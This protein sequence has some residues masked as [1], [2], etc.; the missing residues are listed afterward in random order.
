[1]RKST[2]GWSI[3]LVLL[4]FFGGVANFLQMSMQS[5][6]QGVLLISPINLLTFFLSF[7]TLKFELTFITFLFPRFLEEHV[8]KYRKAFGSCGMK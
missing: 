1:M 7:C 4:D 5:I 6:D 8:W 2:E 3:G